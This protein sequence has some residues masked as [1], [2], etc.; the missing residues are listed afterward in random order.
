[1]RCLGGSAG[2]PNSLAA[3]GPR[4]E[5]A[6]GRKKLDR[7]D[8]CRPEDCF[9]RAGCSHQRAVL[10]RPEGRRLRG[11]SAC[12]DHSSSHR[13]TKAMHIVQPSLRLATILLIPVITGLALAVRRRRLAARRRT[14]SERQAPDESPNKPTPPVAGWHR[15]PLPPPAIAL[16]SADGRTLAKAAISLGSMEGRTLPLGAH[17]TTAVSACALLPAADPNPIPSPNPNPHQRRQ[18]LRRVG[19]QDLRDAV[20]RHRRGTDHR[21]RRSGA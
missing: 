20:R 18:R 11:H 2:S 16:S 12:G 8:V 9:K 14:L 7:A 21:H 10:V 13:T 3:R 17:Y 5:G 19:E 6:A 15:R 4:V 1:M